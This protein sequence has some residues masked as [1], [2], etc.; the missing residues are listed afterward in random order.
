MK[1]GLLMVALLMF[2]WSTLFWGAIGFGRTLRGASRR[3]HK[4]PSHTD[5]A[6]RP[7]PHQDEVAI[8]MAAHNEQAVIGAAVRSACELVR[9]D[10]VFV[11][12]DGSSDDTV[13][14]VRRCGANVLDL[15]PNRGKA[16][17][18]SAAV[19]QFDLAHRA[20]VVVILDADTEL[21]ENYLETGL[22][23]FADP[24]VVVVAGRATTQWHPAG[25]SLIGRA[26]VAHRERIYVCLQWLVKYGQAASSFDAVTIA[27]GFASM[28]RSDVLAQLPIDPPGL[29]IE[30]FNMTFE[31]HLRKLGRIAFVPGVAVA[32]TQD[33]DTLH[34]YRKQT[35]RWALGF[36][37]TV[38]MHGLFH[39]GAFWPL[40]GVYCVELV[41]SSLVLLGTWLVVLTDLVLLGAHSVFGAPVVTHLGPALPFLVAALLLPDLILT[42]I[43]TTLARR[44]YLLAAAPA[45]PFL[46]VLDAWTC[47]RTLGGSFRSGTSGQWQSP[48][49]RA[50]P[51]SPT[52]NSSDPVIAG[53]LTARGT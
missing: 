9:P 26:L 12:S 53:S 21:S 49:R 5:A 18:L 37:Q 23:L 22:A 30:D 47:L 4:Q 50:A 46:R 31:I 44:M 39:R 27:P 7:H 1:L 33:P 48:T 17:A 28:Y 14:I 16:G 38:R 35:R 52:S 11:V 3:D 34:D 8:L 15:Q 41:L 29:V 40:L 51:E 13:E 32:R 20:K 6:V 42:L 10:Q 36:W 24:R 45:Y 2:G 19:Q 43:A 25:L